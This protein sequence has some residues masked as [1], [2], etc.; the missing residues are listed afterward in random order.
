MINCP[1]LATVGKVEN[2]AVHVNSFPTYDV[3][4]PTSRDLNKLRVLRQQDTVRHW[5]SLDDHR[6]CVLCGNEFRGREIE[7]QS[8]QGHIT[9]HC[10]TVGCRGQIRHF[11]FPGNPLMDP[12]VWS[13]WMLALGGADSIEGGVGA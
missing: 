7:I 11:V 8:E 12:K 2:E 9:C 4:T 1:P 13:D 5:H 6:I 10:P 3:I